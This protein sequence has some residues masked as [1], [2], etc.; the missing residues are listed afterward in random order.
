MHHQAD[1]GRRLCK[2]KIFP[3]SLIS[4]RSTI[5]TALHLINAIRGCSLQHSRAHPTNPITR[6]HEHSH[7]RS[8]AEFIADR[9]AIATFPSDLIASRS[10]LSQ[11]QTALVNNNSF[12]ESSLVAPPSPQSYRP[13]PQQ[14][15]Q[16]SSQQPSQITEQVCNCCPNTESGLQLLQDSPQ[17]PFQTTNCNAIS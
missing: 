7:P 10:P 1:H 12:P 14:L 8:S 9:T 6:L 17:Q 3:P 11:L 13:L 2:G 15:L 16:F 4:R 5:A